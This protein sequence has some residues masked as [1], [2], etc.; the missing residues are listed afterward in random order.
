[1]LGPQLTLFFS[2]AYYLYLRVLV[3]V[4]EFGHFIA[5]KRIGIRVEKFS[6][7]FGPKLSS[8]KRGDTEY[9]IS[10]IPLGGYIKMA[11]DE[12][13]ESLTG[14]S[15]EFLSRSVWERFLVIFAGPLLNYI[16]ALHLFV[17]LF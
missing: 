9:L 15:F 14:K 11:G 8:V 16:L 7:G 13:G 4:H 12:P 10:A 2:S 1:M 3:M 6:F 5:A 17:I